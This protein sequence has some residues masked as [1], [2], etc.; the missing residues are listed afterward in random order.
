[1]RHTGIGAVWEVEG[2]GR[3]GQVGECDRN[4]GAGL[5]VTYSEAINRMVWLEE[6][7]ANLLD[8]L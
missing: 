4:G 7:R 2:S 6:T 3:A 1:M 5:Q 8:R